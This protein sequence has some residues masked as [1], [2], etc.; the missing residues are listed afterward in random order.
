MRSVD[1]DP[2][3]RRLRSAL[4]STP[5]CQIVAMAGGARRKFQ[6]SSR[7][8]G[9]LSIKLT[10]PEQCKV[11]EFIESAVHLSFAFRVKERV[12]DPKDDSA[13]PAEE[14][15]REARI[16]GTVVSEVVVAS[17]KKSRHLGSLAHP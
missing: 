9:T 16:F 11:S 13:R 7:R 14:V 17:A 4:L 8:D 3:R 10:S 12:R 6:A 1:P 5:S 15:G 2:L